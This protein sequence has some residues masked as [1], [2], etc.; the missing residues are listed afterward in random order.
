MKSFNKIIYTLMGVVLL[1][2]TS[3]QEEIPVRE[4]SPAAPENSM[5]VLFSTENPTSV[6]LSLTA[7]EYTIELKRKVYNAEAVVPV[8]V[9]CDEVLSCPESVTFAAGDSTASYTI[10]LKDG[11]EPFV[12]Y[13]AE[14][15]ISNDF[16]NPYLSGENGTQEYCVNIMKND[17]KNYSNGVY[18]SYFFGDADGNPAQWENIMQ[19]SEILKQYKLLDV[20]EFGYDILFEVDEEGGVSLVEGDDVATGYM[21]PAYGMIYFEV[22]PTST[23]ADGVVTLVGNM[24]VSAGSFG[25]TTEGYVITEE[26]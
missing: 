17:W 14:I 22:L 4:P 11:M 19:Y 12:S 15:R 20:Y 16:T 10:T 7:T 25:G 5:D 26:Y 3:C 6:E 2:F 24:N 9:E 23:F 13:M 1:A 18:V 21:H 8:Q